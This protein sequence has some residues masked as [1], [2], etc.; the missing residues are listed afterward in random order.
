[1]KLYKWYKCIDKYG[2]PCF[3][4]EKGFYDLSEIRLNYKD[5]F[6]VL[7]I[8]KRT[9]SDFVKILLNNKV[10]YIFFNPNKK[11]DTDNIIQ[12]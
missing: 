12:L 9:Y 10:L 11:D 1:M 8:E 7:E 3:N 4:N 6:F 5:S 2:W